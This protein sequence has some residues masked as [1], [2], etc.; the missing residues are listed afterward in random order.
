MNVIKKERYKTLKIVDNNISI[1]KKY[2][3]RLIGETRQFY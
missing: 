3:G 2:L 1:N